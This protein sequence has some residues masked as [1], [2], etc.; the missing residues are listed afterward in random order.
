MPISQADHH[1]IAA[2]IHLAE[3]GT[4]GE[5]VCVLARAAGGYGEIPAVMA[6]VLALALPW[7]LVEW[8]QWTVLHILLAQLVCYAALWGLFSLPAVSQRLVPRAMQR[9]AAHR[10]AMEQFV[11][12]SVSRTAQRTGILIFVSLA[13]RYARIVADDGIAAKIPPERWQAI[14]DGLIAHTR[15]DRIADGFVSAISAC[16]E[17]LKT[18]F[19]ADGADANQLPDRLYVM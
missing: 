11:V 10:A 7:A 5:I 18:H 8:T 4:S 1:R 13:E 17:A 12:R 2:A 19:P 14:V 3:A 15:Q 16:G 9:S 6:A